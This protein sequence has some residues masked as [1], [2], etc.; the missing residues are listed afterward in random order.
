MIKKKPNR[1]KGTQRRRV[2]GFGAMPLTTLCNSSN[3][4]E[5]SAAGLLVTVSDVQLS[6]VMVC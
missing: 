4:I 6:P 5:H 3:H 2:T 1:R